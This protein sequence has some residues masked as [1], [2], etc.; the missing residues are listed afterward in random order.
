MSDPITGAVASAVAS[1][2]ASKIVEYIEKSGD[3]EA[4]WKES[5]KQLAIKIRTIYTQNKNAKVSD[6]KAFSRELERY[7]KFATELSVRGQARRFDEEYC[8]LLESLGEKIT[9]LARGPNMS[10]ETMVDKYE[11]ENVDR[12]VDELLEYEK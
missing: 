4:T 5:G 8:D 7:G 2:S 11:N 3:G 6:D 10:D 9:N 1:R 12:L